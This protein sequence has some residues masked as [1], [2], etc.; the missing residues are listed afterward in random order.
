MWLWLLLA[1]VGCFGIGAFIGAPYLPVRRIDA[2][3]A[4]DLAE[5]KAGEI[6]IDLGSGDG[7]LLLMA[8][9]RGAKGIGYEINPLLWL[10]SLV[11]T[12]RYRKSITIYCRS[13]WLVKLPPADVI[14]T[15]LID[16]YTAKL[17]RKL[18]T[19][20]MK[21]TRVVSY[22]FALPRQAAKQTRNTFLYRYP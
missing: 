11:V 8:A 2:A 18:N 7:R 19:E 10:W 5:L 20:L 12:W 4:L 14:Y 6:L 15:F 13:Y 22:V 9:Q 1:I 17:D 21:P 3:A 16:R